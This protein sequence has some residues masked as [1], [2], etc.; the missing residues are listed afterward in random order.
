MSG[1]AN[2]DWQLCPPGELGRLA[3]RLRA[4][5]RGR[6]VATAGVA[7]LAAAAVAFSAWQVTGG[8]DLPSFVGTPACPEDRCAPATPPACHDT[9][10]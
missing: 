10:P 6:A 5:R 8:F 9:S 7:L 4:R 1:P 2:G 3:G